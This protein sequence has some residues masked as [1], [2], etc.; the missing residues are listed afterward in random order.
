MNGTL[1]P[2]ALDHNAN[3]QQQLQ[4][5]APGAS[6][7]DFRLPTLG[8]NEFNEFLNTND[9]NFDSVDDGMMKMV[10][11]ESIDIDFDSIFK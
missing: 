1:G 6:V 4:P 8:P 2:G 7:D 5:P 11:M 9:T 10:N 3:L